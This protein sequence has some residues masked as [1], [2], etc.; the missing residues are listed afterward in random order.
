M[1][2]FECLMCFN[3]YCNMVMF[4][5]NDQL[6]LQIKYGFDYTPYLQNGNSLKCLICYLWKIFLIQT[7]L[8]NWYTIH[9]HLGYEK[10]VKD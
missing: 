10:F 9:L 8:M 5:T 6:V 2:E 1:N 3:V 4:N 7:R